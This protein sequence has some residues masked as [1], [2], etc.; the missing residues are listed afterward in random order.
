M[1]YRLTAAQH[2]RAR[3]LPALGSSAVL[4]S[5]RKLIG[6]GVVVLL[7]LAVVDMPYVS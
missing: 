4:F 2:R 7:Y 5:G 1:E 3:I 6:A